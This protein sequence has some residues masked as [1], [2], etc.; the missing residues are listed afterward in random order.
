MLSWTGKFPDLLAYFRVKVKQMKLA[1][2]YE[3]NAYEPEI[4]QLWESA[5]AFAPRKQ[6]SK[7]HFSIVLPP[8]NANGNLHVGHALVIAVEDVMARYHRLKGESTAFLPG[9]DHAG[10]ETWVVFEK[11]L[12]KQGKT[13]FNF[14][15]EQLYQ[16]VWDFVEAHRGNMEI[17]LRELGASLDWD[18]CCF[19]LDKKVIDRSY[20]TFK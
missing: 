9:A 4:Y 6:G 8:P 10:F 3:P 12:E 16:M 18:N 5:K 14:S 17:Q 2:T 15:R 11:E 7:G 1:K 20:K 13:R 19:S